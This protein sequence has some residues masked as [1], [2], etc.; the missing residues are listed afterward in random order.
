[1]AHVRMTREEMT[2]RAI[3]LSMA[4]LVVAML[5]A[6]I[7]GTI[8]STIGPEI[9]T[10]LGGL[11][12]Y[13]W[14]ITAYMLCETIMIPISG[15]MSDIY[16]RRPFFLVG[17]I[18]FAGA[19]VAA[20][21][22]TSMEMLIVSRA[23]QGLGGGILIPVVTASV[24]DLYAPE[25]RPKMQG[26]L[27][28]AFGIG[29][30]AGPLVGGYIAE[31]MSWHWAFFIN[32]PLAII[33][34]V[35][36]VKGF[37]S[38]SEVEKPKIDYK[39]VAVLTVL[40][41]DLLIWLT[42][43]GK[44]FEWIG[45]ESFLM[46]VIA[47]AMLVLF[48][49]VERR[50]EDPILSPELFHN[51]TIRLSCIMMFVFG[52]AM[53]G[54]TTYVS[55]YAIKVLGYDTLTAGEYAMAMVVGMIVTS[56]LGGSTVN[57]IGYRIWLVLGPIFA[58][59]GLFLMAFVPDDPS[60]LYLVTLLFIFGLGLGCLM[61]VVTAG[62]QNCANDDDMGM[63]LSS[64]NLVRSIGATSGTAIFTMIIN[65]QIDSGLIDL[66][67][68]DYIYD[69][70]P[71]DTGIAELI[72]L[73]GFEMFSPAIKNLFA[74]SLQYSFGVAAVIVLLLVFVGAFYKVVKIPSKQ[75]SEE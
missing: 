58:S 65:R 2:P 10:D 57:R 21:L 70:I 60:W 22:S 55:M 12:S 28:A 37:P 7:D 25:D 62:V 59:I 43:G 32:V 17:L 72:G 41:T 34:F 39:G 27:S 71:H 49:F 63:T 61:S 40:L 8:V 64:V 52:V 19:S 3:Q 13:A 38:V 54:A 74:D 31:Y 44:D 16:G 5:I 73:P 9:A 66:G 42:Q 29:T 35:L 46:V 48:V 36:A 18:L 56:M 67:L 47:V 4:G 69:V 14:M 68:P 30:G 51:P 50:A 45:V 11:S 6:S 23:F 53:I 24:G 75:V 26:V 1:M 20:G 33:A 15:K